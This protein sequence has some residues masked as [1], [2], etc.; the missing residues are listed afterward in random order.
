MCGII[1]IMYTDTS[2]NADLVWISKALQPFSESVIDWSIDLTDCD[3]VLRISSRTDQS[4]LIKNNLNN[5]GV[6]CEIIEIFT[7][8]LKT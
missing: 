1:I 2:T 4:I 5:F 8:H 6:K 3:K 7:N